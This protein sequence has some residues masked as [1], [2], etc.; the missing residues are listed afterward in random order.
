MSLSLK[1]RVAIVTGGAGGIGSAT[2][3]LLTERGAKVV[4]ADLDG[5]RAAAL[6]ADLPDALAVKV[7]L[8]SEAEI[9]NL[10]T[11][12]LDAYGRLDI[13][14]NNAALLGADVVQADH[15]I[16][17]MT[18]ALWDRTFAVNTRGTMLCC[19]NALKIMEKQGSGSIINTASNLA[20]QGHVIQ[21]AY[22][23]SKAA[24]LQMTRSDRK[25]VV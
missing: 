13:L 8:A 21:A 19:R 23:A 3:R 25:S 12:T 9:E 15:D 17:G 22:S 6:A 16:A 7:D 1:G 11:R 14:D 5:E 24:V 2:C 4:V 20:L 10:F 18:T